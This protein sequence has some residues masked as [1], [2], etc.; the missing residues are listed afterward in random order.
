MQPPLSALFK[1]YSGPRFWPVWLM[2][3]ALRL[4]AWLPLPVLYLLGAVGGELAWRLHRPRRKI[5]LRNLNACFP[6]RTKAEIRAL[7]R[8]HFRSLVIAVLVS[9]VAWWGGK[10]RILRLTRV[11]NRAILEAAQSRGENI[12]FLVPHFTGL[13]CGGAYLS[14]IAPM[15]SMYRRHKNPLMDALIK[16][17]RARFGIV[18]YSRK[19]PAGSLIRLLR[20]GHCFYYMPDQDPGRVH[21]YDSQKGAKKGHPQ[22]VFAPFYAI[23]TATY[24]ALGRIA[25][26]GNATVIPCATRILPWGRG[27]EIIFNPP[28]ADYPCGDE[29][30]DAAQMNRAIEGLIEHAPEQYFWSHRRFKT[31][32]P[33]EPPFYS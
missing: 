30:R 31:R 14:I 2:V 19:A 29:T 16:K 18:Q 5:T 21:D 23:P 28:L 6:R 9:G 27:F 17:Y 33:G 12:I 32:P 13:E 26:L 3:G 1:A 4:L 20:R 24:A 10:A 25:R 8:G 11:Q 15:V 22:G 7:A